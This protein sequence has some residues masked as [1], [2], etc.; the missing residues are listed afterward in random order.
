MAPGFHVGV[1]LQITLSVTIIDN[2]LRFMG[3]RA[4][5]ATPLI[6]YETV[7]SA[8]EALREEGKTPSVRL[9]KRYLGGGSPNSILKHLSDWKAGRPLIRVSEI[10]IDDTVIDGIRQQMA[11][12][13][14][15]AAKGA[16][17]RAAGV[18]EDLRTVS[19]ALHEAEQRIQALETELAQAREATQTAEREG[20]KIG[21]MAEHDA[22][23]AA[24]ALE[25]A[26]SRLQEERERGDTARQDLA[27][28]QVRLEQLPALQD[29]V[30]T[31]R[32]ALAQEQQARQQAEKEKAV[33]DTRAADVIE[34][35][36][37]LKTQAESLRSDLDTLKEEARIMAKE[38]KKEISEL[39]QALNET[40]QA[41]YKL[42]SELARL[43]K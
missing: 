15:G 13:A 2:T 32:A 36:D 38:S 43:S 17:E 29:E 6:T 9:V 10:D 31:L 20:Q 16:E 14:E 5:P 33:A 34:T 19:E 42:E 35:R 12:V 27:Q 41:R 30:K 7:A 3:A 39:R 25:V 18:E 37:S 8:A 4:M 28:A 23:K 24:Q 40:Q 1:I 22:R 21:E 11:R 26:H